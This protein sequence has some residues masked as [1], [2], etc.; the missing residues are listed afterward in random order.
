[1]SL[2]RKS[3]YLKL[4]LALT[5]WKVGLLDRRRQVRAFNMSLVRTFMNLLDS[6]S[7]GDNQEI[8]KNYKVTVW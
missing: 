4:L 2:E 1:M 7:H 6:H 8:G 5:V 3:E